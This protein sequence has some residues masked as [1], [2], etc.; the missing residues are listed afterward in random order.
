MVYTS[1]ECMILLAAAA[2]S[3][4]P[5]CSCKEPK[6]DSCPRC[7]LFSK[8]RNKIHSIDNKRYRD[9]KRRKKEGE[10]VVKAVRKKKINIPVEFRLCLSYITYRYNNTINTNF[11]R[12]KNNRAGKNT[13]SNKVSS[14]EV[15]K[16]MNAC[17]FES[18][19]D[20]V[21]SFE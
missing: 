10:P 9:N 6:V 16:L 18:L 4:E 19:D 7:E 15:K 17:V 8:T 21:S 3:L 12:S 11:S 2:A 13:K 20:F 5:E 1:S 14:T